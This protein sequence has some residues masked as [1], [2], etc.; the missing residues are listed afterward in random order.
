MPSTFTIK[1]N[2]VLPALCCPTIS[3]RGKKTFLKFLITYS[4]DLVDERAGEERVCA[5]NLNVNNDAVMVIMNADGTLVCRLECLVC[6]FPRASALLAYRASYAI[7]YDKHTK[8]G[9]SF[10]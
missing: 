2:S 7:H 6:F 8:H 5:I 3:K 1:Q 9:N 4:H 10:P